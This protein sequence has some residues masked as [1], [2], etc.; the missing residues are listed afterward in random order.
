MKDKLARTLTSLSVLST[1]FAGK[2]YARTSEAKDSQTPG[3]QTLPESSTTA[4]PDTSEQIAETEA[5]VGLG[6]QSDDQAG[7][8]AESSA[9]PPDTGVSLRVDSEESPGSGES[10]TSVTAL[11]PQP[12]PVGPGA[13]L[14]STTAGGVDDSFGFVATHPGD[15][16]LTIDELDVLFVFPDPVA[17]ILNGDSGGGSAPKSE[18][19][20]AA[21]FAGTTLPPDAGFSPTGYEVDGGFAPQLAQSGPLIN[22]DLFLNDARFLGIDGTGFAAVILDTGIDL[23]H[24]FFGPDND[25]DGVADRIVFH[26]DFADDDPDGSDFDNHG[27]N[28]SSIIASEDPV[29]IGMAPGVDIIHLKVFPSSGGLGSFVDIESA[30]IWV[31]A[32]AVTFNIASVNMSLSDSGNYTTAVTSLLSDELT[33]LAAL[34]VITVSSSGNS[35]AQVGSAQGVGYP[36]ADPNSLS[37]G[38]AYDNNI[39]SVS[40]NGSTAFSTDADRLTPFSQRDDSLTDIFAP[41]AAI[42]GANRNGGTVTFHGTSQSSPH[43][44]GIAVL[45]QQLAVQEFGRRL[46]PSEFVQVLNQTGVTI[47]DGDDE[48]DTVINTGLNFQRVDV[49]AMADAIFALAAGGPVIDIDDVTLVEG[50]AGS[51]DAVFTVS[52]NGTSLDPVSVD[53][54]TSDGSATAGSD[55][56]AV[57]D[58]LVIPAGQLSG[59]LTVQVFGDTNVEPDETFTLT[60]SNA[61]GAS[62]GIGSTLDATGTIETDDTGLSIAVLNAVQDERNTGTTAFTFTVTRSGDVSGATD[63]DFTVTGSGADP[64]D[65]GGSFPTGTVSFAASEVTQIVSIDVAADTDVELDEGFTVTLSN[66]SGGAQITGAS[67]IGS[68]QNDDS[69]FSITPLAAD[70]PE[71]DSGTTAFTFTVTRSGDTGPTER[72]STLL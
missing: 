42:T 16:G 38:A 51:V 6:L 69:S 59:T 7:G 56:G 11:S 71:G 40:Y 13:M 50:D 61:K 62:L 48:D 2:L 8:V 10:P 65:F 52:I 25:S 66:P 72:P 23:D 21:D 47:N 34:D 68:I 54:A 17:E 36:S 33:Q 29:R 41:G 70:L 35:F 9:L 37:V 46:T 19:V 44:A 55:Y 32:N 43:I 63:V 57:N 64:A 15:T 14:E 53:Y 67:A 27:S 1:L 31:V 4:E 49:L 5:W 28:V 60:L 58:T 22:H 30:L 24:P 3:S 39:G 26:Y 18:V 45:A 20:V 12:N